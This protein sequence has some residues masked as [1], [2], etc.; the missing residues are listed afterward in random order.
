MS[1]PKTHFLYFLWYYT[2]QWTWGII[3]NI[4]GLVL[5]IYYKIKMPNTRRENYLGAAV[6]D[7]DGSGSMGLGMFIFFRHRDAENAEEVLLHEYGHTVQS[8][9]LGPL[10]IPVIGIPSVVWANTPK[11]SKK[12]VDENISYYRFYPEFGANRTGLR[13]YRRHFM[14]LNQPVM[15]TQEFRD[16]LPAKMQQAAAEV[17]G[18]MHTKE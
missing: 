6:T 9:L 16:S 11:L 5:W 1:K 17:S 4:A 18:E 12:R 15:L 10:L 13:T 7:W 2:M 8:A 3:Q 14:D